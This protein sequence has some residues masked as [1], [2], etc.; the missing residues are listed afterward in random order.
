MKKRALAVTL[1]LAL[2]LA[3]CGGGG[4]QGSENWSHTQAPP[5]TE[6]VLCTGAVIMDGVRLDVWDIGGKQYVAREEAV[7]AAGAELSGDTLALDGTVYM[8]CPEFAAA[9]GFPALTDP[10]DGTVYI[11]P[12][13]AEFAISEKTRVPVLMYHALGD[14]AWGIDTLFVRPADFEEQLAYLLQSGFDPIW[15]TDLAHIEDYDRPVILTFDD[16]YDDNYTLLLPILQK[17]NVKAT[18]FVVTGLVG[19]P[20][21]LTA[22]QIRALSDSGLV[23]VQSHTVHHRELTELDREELER[24]FSDARLH[25]ARLTGR[26]PIAVSYPSGENDQLVRRT[27]GKYYRFGVKSNGLIWNT[28]SDPLQVKRL[29]VPRGVPI[30]AFAR[31]MNAIGEK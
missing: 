6:P 30:R 5:G 8:P 26:I 21:Y 13:A 22:E 9:N 18:V 11:S 10:E 23:S 20:H 1:L 19:K 28:G 7:A 15:F 31:M 27:A 24:E 3:A 14:E 12:S 2:F 29:I 4:G 25:I 17:Y 16:G